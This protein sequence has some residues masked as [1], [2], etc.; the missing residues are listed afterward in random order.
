M[1]RV[2]NTKEK[3]MSPGMSLP[4]LA[5]Y[6]STIYPK[7]GNEIFLQEIG[8]KDFNGIELCEGDTVRIIYPNSHD[9]NH[10][11]TGEIVFKE[12]M[13]YCCDKSGDFIDNLES[14]N[15]TAKF[16]YLGNIYQNPELLK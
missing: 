1:I 13:F 4:M 2:W 15:Q 8:R 14:E 5:G 16:E 9:G 3:T 7:L 11:Y 10:E 12:C 6:L